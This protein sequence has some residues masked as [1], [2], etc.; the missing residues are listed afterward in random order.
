MKIGQ[1]CFQIIYDLCELAVVSK[2]QIEAEWSLC[3]FCN[4]FDL[5]EDQFRKGD[6]IWLT[7]YTT[8]NENRSSFTVHKKLLGAYPWSLGGVGRSIDDCLFV[9]DVRELF[10]GLQPATVFLEIRFQRK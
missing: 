9:D 8:P 5:D 1:I 6:K 4:A 10:G 7:T 3:I 2:G